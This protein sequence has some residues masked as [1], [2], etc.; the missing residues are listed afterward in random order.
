MKDVQPLHDTR[1]PS[2]QREITINPKSQTGGKHTWDLHGM[3]ISEAHDLTMNQI[4]HL[5]NSHKYVTFITGKSGI[6]NQEFT[7]WLDGNPQVRKVDVINGGGA[8]RVWFK[9]VRQKRS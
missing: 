7:H 3:T 9:K 2:A 4:D 6:M 1:V 5:K 8:Y